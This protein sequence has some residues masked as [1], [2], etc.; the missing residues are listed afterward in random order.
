MAKRKNQET[1]SQKMKID[2]E[3]KLKAFGIIKGVED[4]DIEIDGEQ[5]TG[6][7]DTTVGTHWPTG[8]NLNG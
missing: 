8:T 3:E 7:K 6:G 4:E 1:E 5:A 2:S